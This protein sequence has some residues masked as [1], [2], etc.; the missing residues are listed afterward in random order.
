MPLYSLFGEG[1]GYRVT[2]VITAVIVAIGVLVNP[3]SWM[4]IAGVVL[5]GLLIWAGVG[6]KLK[7]ILIK[8]M[9]VVFDTIDRSAGRNL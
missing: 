4:K 1:V 2:C 7:T 6:D 9:E 3:N 5:F 8:L